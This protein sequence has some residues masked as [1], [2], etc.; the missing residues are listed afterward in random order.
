M[1]G[2]QS[3]GAHL[4]VAEI[5][6]LDELLRRIPDKGRRDAVTRNIL[7]RIAVKVEAEAKRRVPRR[8]GNTQRSITHRLR[9]TGGQIAEYIGDFGEAGAR[10]AAW[11]EFGTGVFGPRG[12]RIVP[13]HARAMRWP[14]GNTRL[15][16]S[17]RTGAAAEFAFARSTKGMRAQ[18]FMMPGFEASRPYH[19]EVMNAAAAELFGRTNPPVVVS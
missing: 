3:P 4:E 8:T 14:V 6:G 15:T 12:M 17:H 1:A 10:T 16:G 7:T 18:P 19:Q 5:Q 2:E 11:L 13:K 9:D